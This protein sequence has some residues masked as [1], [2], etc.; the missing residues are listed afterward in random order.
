MTI[1]L[2]WVRWVRTSHASLRPMQELWGP[3]T[4][5]L[6]RS[7]SQKNS[8]K[9]PN[10]STKT[11][12]SCF[13]AADVAGPAQVYQTEVG[14]RL[15]KALVAYSVQVR[16]PYTVL[17]LQG[18]AC[19]SA[20]QAHIQQRS[21]RK[22]SP[23]AEDVAAAHKWKGDGKVWC[24]VPSARHEHIPVQRGPASKRF[25][26]VR[27]CRDMLRAAAQGVRRW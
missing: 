9:K 10:K 5:P 16:P 6:W 27:P 4:R 23:T 1:D 17:P 12:F 14:L 18:G 24:G 22:G 20:V 21:A 25:A 8:T 13:G 11:M 26:P 15:L 2:S 19:D 3:P 7:F